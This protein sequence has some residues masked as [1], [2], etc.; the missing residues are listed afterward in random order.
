MTNREAKET[1]ARKFYERVCELTNT[2]FDKSTVC[3]HIIE[4]TKYHIAILHERF[5]RNNEK[6]HKVSMTLVYNNNII[7]GREYIKLGSSDK[8]IMNRFNKLVEMA[9]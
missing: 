1:E 7:I 4:G 3:Y 6:F 2:E 9:A 5:Y 8:V